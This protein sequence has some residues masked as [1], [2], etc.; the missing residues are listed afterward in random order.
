MK[1]MGKVVKS[2]RS[3]KEKIEFSDEAKLLW[4]VRYHSDTEDLQTDLIK[5]TEGIKRGIRAPV[6][7]NA[8]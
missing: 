5:M 7:I 1:R 4:A 6:Q 3:S 8:Q 2:V